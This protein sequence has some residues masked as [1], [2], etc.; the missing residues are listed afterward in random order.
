MLFKLTKKILDKFKPKEK[1]FYVSVED[2][3]YRLVFLVNSI[4]EKLQKQKEI[5][6]KTRIKTLDKD[7]LN[8]VIDDGDDFSEEAFGRAMEKSQ[9]LN[10]I[11]NK[12][13]KDEELLEL[14]LFIFKFANW[15]ITQKMLLYPSW[16]RYDISAEQVEE[17]FKSFE[18]MSVG[19]V[20]EI[21]ERIKKDLE[22]AVKGKDYEDWICEIEVYP[23]NKIIRNLCVI[24]KVLEK[25]QSGIFLGREERKK[26]ETNLGLA[27][28]AILSEK[29][30]QV[31]IQDANLKKELDV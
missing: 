23:V 30:M 21:Q 18:L 3:P 27:E 13:V 22:S 12:T 17:W 15:I 9:R 19:E 4:Y 6:I 1:A 5:S 8:D 28:L 24:N 25:R 20:K 31:V 10:D 16:R 11:N 26:L 29:I 14:D 2:L 7:D